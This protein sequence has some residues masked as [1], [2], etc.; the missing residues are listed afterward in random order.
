M[1]GLYRWPWLL[2]IRGM[3]NFF[4]YITC[5]V[6]I[7]IYIY[8]LSTY[9]PFTNHSSH[10]KREIDMD[11]M[12]TDDAGQAHVTGIYTF[13]LNSCVDMCYY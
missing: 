5:G 8:H 13:I 11:D 7:Y 10:D 4:V 9:G 12:F 1:F 2:S 3:R 6:Y